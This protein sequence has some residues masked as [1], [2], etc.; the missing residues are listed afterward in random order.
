[1]IVQSGIKLVNKFILVLSQFDTKYV[2]SHGERRPCQRTKVPRNFA[3][4][5]EVTVK[6]A[7]RKMRS[8]DALGQN[9]NILASSDSNSRRFGLLKPLGQAYAK[10]VVCR[11]SWVQSK[12]LIAQVFQRPAIIAY[13]SDAVTSS[14]SPRQVMLN[15]YMML[16]S[17]RLMLGLGP[18][19]PSHQHLI[20]IVFFHAHVLQISD[21][22]SN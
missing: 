18:I 10:S 2:N 12:E 16:L 20:A 11:V 14:S 6:P 21:F 13:C 4:N 9:N 8:D 1:M 5:L 19:Q 7:I 15:G 17:L 22:Q 3:W